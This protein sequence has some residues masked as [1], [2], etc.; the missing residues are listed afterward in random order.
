MKET[1]LYTQICLLLFTTALF[2]ACHSQVLESKKAVLDS[3][4]NTKSSIAQYI[5]KV[6][7]DS[8]GKLWFGTMAKGVACYNGKT[9]TYF[10]TK[11]GLC[12]NTVLSITEDKEG[13]LWFGTHTGASRYNGKS[14]TNFTQTKG[15]TGA[16]CNL[17]ITSKGNIWAG[18]NDGAFRYDGYSFSRFEIPD[19]GIVKPSYKWVA[20]K[21]WSLIEDSKGNIW[22]GRDGLGACKF[23][24]KSFT[25]FTKKDGLCSNNVSKVL[26]DK[27][28]NIWFGSLTS[29][30]P[31][32]TQEGGVSC[33]NGTTFTQYPAQEGLHKNDIYTIYEDKAGNV[34]IGA[35]GYGAYCYQ[36][37]KFKL[38]RKSNPKD[39]SFGIQSILEDKN[40]VL[41][42][43]FSGGLF[44]FNGQSFVH[45]S[46]NGPWK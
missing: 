13:N 29:D 26:E 43:G 46:P 3:S 41:W 12:G 24:G 32:Y 33:Y 42:F 17:L 5:V 7:E 8:K 45:V 14:F 39:L 20:G 28:G 9:L 25:H 44:R 38:F 30:Y 18:T 35:T 15:L 23:D 6:F 2:T 16:G 34:W 11:D 27:Q 40:G 36:G 10:T 31:Q 19:P 37:K 21:V 4:S 22:F 1:Y